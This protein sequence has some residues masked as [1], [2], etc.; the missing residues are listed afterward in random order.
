ME[1]VEVMV[2]VLPVLKVE[3]QCSVERSNS[4]RKGEWLLE[5]EH[6]AARVSVATRLVFVLMCVQKERQKEDSLLYKNCPPSQ[7]NRRKR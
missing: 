2:D 3:L 5:Y 1:T 6:D 4:Y 7:R